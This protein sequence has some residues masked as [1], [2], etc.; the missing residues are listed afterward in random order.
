MR[1]NNNIRISILAILVLAA[2]VFS[3]CSMTK[4]LASDE[5]LLKKNEIKLK[6]DIKVNK[7][8]L[9]E[10][11]RQQPNRKI[12]GVFPLY[13]WAYNIP[14]PEKFETRDAK[15][16]IKLAKK[17]EKRRKKDKKPLEF[18][19][20]GSIR[21]REILLLLPV[22]LP[23]GCRHFLENM[24]SRQMKFLRKS[25]SSASQIAREHRH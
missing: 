17:N 24:P 10:T 25:Q 2:T 6:D 1:K 9:F 8:D 18:K 11:I 16:R 23:I 7:N 14:N 22:H 3:S 4:R 13:V 19:P 12:L 15:R 20:F 5:V 21:S